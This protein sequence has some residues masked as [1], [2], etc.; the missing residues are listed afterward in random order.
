MAGGY[1]GK[2]LNVNLSTGEMKE[3]TPDESLY[4][5]FIGGYGIGARD[6]KSVV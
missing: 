6:R 1:L 5:D 2:F 3:E 4:K